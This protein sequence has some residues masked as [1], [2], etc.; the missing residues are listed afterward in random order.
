[1]P[2]HAPKGGVQSVST[3]RL[4][5]DDPAGYLAAVRRHMP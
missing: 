4:W 1:M 2:G 5:T 3:V